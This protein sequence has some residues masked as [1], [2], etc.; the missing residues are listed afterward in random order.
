PIIQERNTNANV[1]KSIQEDKDWRRQII[2]PPKMLYKNKVNIINLHNLY[3]FT[4]ISRIC[5]L[6]IYFI[7]VV[8][9]NYKLK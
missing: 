8:T 6:N 9:R 1:K 7:S 3:Y 5:Y 4:K 2:T